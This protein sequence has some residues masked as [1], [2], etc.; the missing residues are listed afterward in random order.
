M[1]HG[2]SEKDKIHAGASDALII[3]LQ[4]HLESFFKAFEGWN[5]KDWK[6][7]KSK[8]NDGKNTKTALT[9]EITTTSVTTWKE[10]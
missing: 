2:V 5:L 9:K 8:I 7:E 10:G 4:V 3:L 1:N 6:N